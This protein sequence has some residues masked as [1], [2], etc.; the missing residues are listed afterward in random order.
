MW[1]R[2]NRFERNVDQLEGKTVT[3]VEDLAGTI[4]QRYAG[5]T[6]QQLANNLAQLAHSIEQ[7]DLGESMARR[8]KELERAT[9]KASRRMNHALKD[10]EKTRGRVQRDAGALATR[11]SHDAGA[12]A[13]QAREQVEHG[14]QQLATIS[15]KA[16]PTEPAA[17]IAPSLLGF[18]L[19]FGL[20]FLFARRRRR[21]E[22]E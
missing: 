11:V 9:R 12:L 16:V 10:L 6:G 14:G 2:K 4:R 8:R 19:G 5:E 3:A 17:W 21:A 18:G 22:K 13:V 20:G 1:N 15:Q 7:L